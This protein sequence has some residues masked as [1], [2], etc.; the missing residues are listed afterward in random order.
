MGDFLTFRRMITPLLI[1]IVF[2]LGILAIIGAGLVAILGDDPRIALGGVLLLLFGP[3][4]LRVYCELLILTFRMNET[5]TDIDRA[6]RRR[7]LPDYGPEGYSPAPQSSSPR[8]D[9]QR[10]LPYR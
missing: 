9:Y 6:L 4:V 2:W 7:A 3:I 10:G 8:Q 5:L 1:Q